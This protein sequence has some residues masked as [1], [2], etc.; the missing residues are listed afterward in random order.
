MP[1]FIP[2]RVAVMATMAL[3]ATL[4]FALPPSPAEALPGGVTFGAYAQP[5]GGE[6]N[7]DAIIKLENTLGRTLPMVRG[8][9]D[10]DDKMGEDKK[11]HRWVRDGGR[12][13]MVS[14]KPVR[15]DGSQVRWPSIA[16]ASAGSRLY[17]EIV[18]LAR[19]AKRFGEPMIIGFHHEPEHKKNLS[20]GTSSDYRAAF[21]RI[22]QIFDAQGVTNVSFAWIMTSWS[23]EV[24]DNNPTDRRRAHLWY[25]GDDVIDFISAQTY[26][27]NNCRGG[28]NEPWESLQ[29]NIEPFMR[30][31]RQH[32]SK[33][34]ILGEWGSDEGS[35][36]QKARWLDDV[37][38]LFKS[39]EYKDRFAAVLYFHDSAAGE[40]WPSCTW[41]LNSSPET[42]SAAK[43]LINDSFYRVPVSA[44]GQTPPPPAPTP[45]AP[46]PEPVP[47]PAPPAPAPPPAPVAVYCNGVLATIVGTNGDDTILGTSGRDVI[48]ALDGNDV[49][50]GADGNDLVCGGHGNDRIT[51]GPGNDLLRGGQ[52]RDVIDGNVGSDDLRGGTGADRLRGNSGNDFIYG[53]A[54]NDELTGG[55]GSDVLK[56]GLGSDKHDGGIGTDRCRDTSGTNIFLNC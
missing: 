38:A 53:Q 35:I 9:S 22:T 16:S 52:G 27:W 5:V 13:L 23:F 20:F 42:L 14:V 44:P 18:D 45:T 33:K 48:H 21:R 3:I 15:N 50:H 32:P 6:N 28:G 54:G 2:H 4:L 43:R 31:A 29:S 19:G 25:P 49:I 8:F 39:G 41:W 11:F 56:G 40:G 30:F 34:L 47:A 12:Q 7:T 55:G 24:G 26:N 10:W 46:I 1:I 51:G 37:R 17:N 36:G